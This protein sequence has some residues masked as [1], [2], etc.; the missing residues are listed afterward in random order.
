MYMTYIFETERLRARLF[1][2]ADA[3]LVFD[4]NSDP[5]VTRYTGDGPC[6]DLRHAQEIL[7]T[8]ILPQYTLYGI[9]RWALELKSTG[10]FIGWCGVKLLDENKEYDLGYRFFPKYWGLGYATESAKASLDYVHK[11]GIERITGHAAVENTGSVNVL[12]KLGMKHERYGQEDIGQV[13]F[14]V[15]D[16]RL[17]TV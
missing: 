12:K 2:L 14:Y 7:E 9:G 17:I 10:D 16:F 4:L 15:S 3:Q 13:V 11:L 5:A 6:S 1:T 8:I